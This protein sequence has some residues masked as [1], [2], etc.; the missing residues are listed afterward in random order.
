MSK[1][2]TVGRASAKPLRTR[3]TPRSQPRSGEWRVFI[4]DLVLTC[5][6]GVHQHERVANQRIRLN[7]D[8][9]V[10]DQGP[11]DDDLEKVVCYGE[12]MTGIRHVVGAG[13]VNLVETLAE[14][15]AAMCLEDARVRSARVRIEKLDVFSEAESVGVEIER[16]QT[17][18]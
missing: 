7:L 6:I 11:M 12:L 15:L 9:S 18:P 16:Y 14:R 13:H 2:K 8:L 5:R 1:A 17:K 3:S 4:R 10:A